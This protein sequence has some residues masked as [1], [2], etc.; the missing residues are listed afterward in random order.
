[1]TCPRVLLGLLAAC[2]AAPAAA[3]II[4]HDVPDEHYRDLGN[5]YRD[6]FVE[7][8]IPGRD[9]IPVIGNGGGTLIGPDWVVTAAH[10]A[11]PIMVGHPRSRVERAHSVLVNGVPYQIE[12][13]VLHPDWSGPGADIAE[14]A[15]TDIALIKLST[16]VVGGRPACLYSRS[17]EAGKVVTLVGSGIFGDGTTGPVG[18]A[19][20][21]IGTLRGSTV[22]VDRTLSDARLIAWTFRGP[23]DPDA[24]R[25]EGISG[26]GDSGGP[27]LLMD[28]DRLCIAG[29]SSS[30]DGNGHGEGRY[31]VREFYP[32][33]S[34]YRS[35]LLA[36]MD[37]HAA[38]ARQEGAGA[39]D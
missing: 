24:T 33:I 38:T 9:G 2:V 20:R 27:A 36:V 21:D 39:G 34:H 28:G 17:D 26:P 12:R 16:P 37:D 14:A 10:A 23:D 32:R 18:G 11:E 13:I 25:L 5:Q 8:A 30:Q 4:R 19:E 35:W 31:G 3:I 1:M 22:T 29:V 15:A 6:T 7:L